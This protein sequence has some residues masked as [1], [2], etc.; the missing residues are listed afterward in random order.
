M[1]SGAD[2]RWMTYRE[3]A[4]ARGI[5]QASATRLAFRRKWQRQVGN[6][7]TAKVLV[8]LAEAM[9]GKPGASSVT[10]GVM[11][12][13]AHDVLPDITRTISVLEAA[14]SAIREQLERE[15]SRSDAAEARAAR[16]EAELSAATVQIRAGRLGT[17]SRR[18]AGVFGRLRM[19]L[20]G[21][22]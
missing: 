14:L 11:P 10:Q 19:V 22:R 18:C 8:R 4:E 1:G 12:H 17:N 9:P 6:S 21:W 3:L 7:G 2:S 16:L 5:T 15:R 13:S 20:R